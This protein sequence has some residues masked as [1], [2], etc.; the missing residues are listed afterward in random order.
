MIW[1]LSYMREGMDKDKIA[2]AMSMHPYRVGKYMSSLGATEPDEIRAMID[3]CA[4]C[5]RILK[6]SDGSYDPLIRLVCTIPSKRKIVR[7]I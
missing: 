4:E 1:I 7:G 2:K 3:R 5:D 6:S